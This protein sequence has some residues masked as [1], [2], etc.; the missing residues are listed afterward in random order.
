MPPARVPITTAGDRTGM[1]RAGLG[2]RNAESVSRR[3]S[4]RTGVLGAREPA[5]E[6]AFDERR[7]ERANTLTRPGLPLH[8]TTVRPWSSTR[9][10]R[11]LVS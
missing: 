11:E 6:G 2:A 1:L 8:S 10:V 5:L 7:Y 3:A 4:C 9:R